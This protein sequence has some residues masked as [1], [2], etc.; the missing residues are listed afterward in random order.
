M[1]EL[2]FRATTAAVRRRA[3]SKIRYG[4][5]QSPSPARFNWHSLTIARWQPRTV[6]GQPLSMTDTKGLDDVVV[7]HLSRRMTNTGY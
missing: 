5:D 3:T 6:K 4:A 7:E 1:A 2:F